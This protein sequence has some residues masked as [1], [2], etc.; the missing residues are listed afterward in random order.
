VRFLGGLTLLFRRR[1]TGHS[2]C[3]RS[4]SLAWYYPLSLSLRR[5]RVALPN[6]GGG[7]CKWACHR[8]AAARSAFAPRRVHE[9][10]CNAP[11]HQEKPITR[12][13]RAGLTSW[14]GDD[15][16]L[17]SARSASL[18]HN[19]CCARQCQASDTLRAFTHA[20]PIGGDAH[21]RTRAAAAARPRPPHLTRAPCRVPGLGGELDGGR[22]TAGG[23]W[24]FEIQ[25]TH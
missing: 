4:L 5:E 25:I 12:Q 18:G 24:R 1:V 23:G 13:D 3:K 2:Q 9:R 19:A 22:P 21:L 11:R 16:L 14:A 15:D 8:Q 6:G 10:S 17:Q 20:R 7:S